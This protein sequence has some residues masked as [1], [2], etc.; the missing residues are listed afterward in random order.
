MHVQKLHWT[1]E[2]AIPWKCHALPCPEI[3]MLA[4]YSIRGI[5][6]G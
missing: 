4:V 1:M 3:A 6:F 5:T 2:I